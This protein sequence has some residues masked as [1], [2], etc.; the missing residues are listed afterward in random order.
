MWQ[1]HKQGAGGIVGDEMGLGKTVQVWCVNG[2]IIEKTFY[3]L[4]AM[5]FGLCNTHDRPR[6]THYT[7]GTSEM[8]SFDAQGEF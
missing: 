8:F 1:L 3:A 2:G 5:L 6:L 4:R 7:A